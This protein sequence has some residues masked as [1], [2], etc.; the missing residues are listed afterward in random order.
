MRGR[1]WVSHAGSKY[2]I[3]RSDCFSFLWVPMPFP[4]TKMPSKTIPSVKRTRE[5][6]ALGS[7]PFQIR[8]LRRMRRT[9]ART[10]YRCI[11]GR[12]NRLR[13]RFRRER[14]KFRTLWRL[15]YD[16]WTT[17]M[18]GASAEALSPQ[19][20][21]LLLWLLWRSLESCTGHLRG[22]KR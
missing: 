15:R 3:P 5:N 18:R 7:S 16:C 20:A 11:G 13:I 9:V 1:E 10:V 17:C 19:T 2:C 4:K 6:P 21:R 22:G 14:K 12:R 8:I